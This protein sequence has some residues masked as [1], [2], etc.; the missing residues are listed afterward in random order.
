M[1]II[2]L[3]NI[4]FP[5][6]R[7]HGVQIMEM[8]RAFAAS[9]V[10]VELVVPRRKNW[11]KENPF[12]YYDLPKTFSITYLHTWDLVQW[13]KIGFL[14]QMFS[15]ALSSFWYVRNTDTLIYSRDEMVLF[16]LSFFGKRFVYEIH[17]PR[18]QTITKHVVSQAL[19]VVPISQGLK[20]FYRKKGIPEEDM[21]VAPDG[22]NLER[23]TV[24][25]TQKECREKLSLP[26][27]ARIALYAG[28]LYAR[29]GA[30]VFAQASRDIE[31]VL[32][33]FVGG[34]VEDI[35]A[36]QKDS[37]RQKN[38]LILG[39][40]S[41]QDVP[42]YLRAADM[43]ILPNSAKDGDANL[44]TSPM[45]LFEYMASGT[46]ILASDVPSLKE[47][48]NDENAL[49]VKPDDPQALSAGIRKAFLDP[50]L[51][52]RAKQAKKD[53]EQYTWQVR[54][55]AVLRRISQNIT[56]EHS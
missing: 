22:V 14:T 50:A 40:K 35:A 12:T 13:G 11:I 39:H 4:R 45:K 9:G 19:F 16:P 42:F 34:T 44:Y 23:F 49:F 29:K 46:P 17:T 27:H 41:H 31:D 48:L 36:F 25:L 5:T 8:C 26:L 10:D 24:F 2:Y 1:K 18:W 7:A 54:A 33:V 51:M 28:H 47:I 52:H 15:F 32:C 56:R 21:L 6:E 20:S 3:A 38:V 43:L 37:S 30:H 53:V 55:E